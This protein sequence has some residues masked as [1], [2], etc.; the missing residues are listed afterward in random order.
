MLKV[1]T[2]GEFL[3]LQQETFLTASYSEAYSLFT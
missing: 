2:I 3:L 1:V